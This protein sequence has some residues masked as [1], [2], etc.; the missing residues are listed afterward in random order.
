MINIQLILGFHTSQVVSRI[1]AINSSVT[2]FCWF[3]NKATKSRR[4]FHVELFKK[5][6]GEVSAKSFSAMPRLS[7]K[8]LLGRKNWLMYITER[9]LRVQ[10]VGKSNSG[11]F[12]CYFFVESWNPLPSW[13]RISSNHITTMM[14]VRIEKSGSNWKDAT[15][16]ETFSSH[17]CLGEELTLKKN[18]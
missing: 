7:K 15:E 18:P 4:S 16:G 14:L 2:Q 3:K 17:C 9:Y 13:N 6:F 8:N 11:M 12:H 1:S 10:Y 5:T